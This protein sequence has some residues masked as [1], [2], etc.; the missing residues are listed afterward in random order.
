[1]TTPDCLILGDGAAGLFLA[2]ALLGRGLRVTVCGKTVARPAAS[3]AAGGILSPLEPWLEPEPIMQLARRG[4]QLFPILV[5]GLGR[6]TGT[7][8]EYDTCGMLAL[9]PLDRRRIDAWVERQAVAHEWLDGERLA[10][11]EPA[12]DP[13]SSGGLLLPEVAQ[14]RNPRLL[15]AL[16]RDLQVRGV[17]FRTGDNIRLLLADGRCTGVDVDGERL[18]AEQVVVAAGAWS[19]ELLSDCMPDLAVTPVRGQMLAFQA[20]PGLLRHIVLQAREYVI[21]RRDGLILAGSTVE[22]VGFDSD[23]TATAAA[24]LRAMAARLVPQLGQ[25]APVHHWSGLRPATADGLPYIGRHPAV[26]GLYVNYGHFRNGILLAPAS[27]ELLADIM[28]DD[29]DGP[30]VAAFAPDRHPTE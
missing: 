5:A 19:S 22:Q 4:Q 30:L 17:H 13:S 8:A 20:E 11:L 27:A 21:P 3:W 24:S 1:M 14:V 29:I 16:R 10:A 2:R 26:T 15:K 25:L 7:D 12:V 18:E 6:D 9:E 28:V 23:T